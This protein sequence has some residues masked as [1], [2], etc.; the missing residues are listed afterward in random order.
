MRAS[1][2]G[3]G[4]TRENSL[5][6][7]ALRRRERSEWPAPELGSP[8]IDTQPSYAAVSQ[9]ASAQQ[10]SVAAVKPPAFDQTPDAHLVEFLA[11]AQ[12]ATSTIGTGPTTKSDCGG[13]S[14][15]SARR[16]PADVFPS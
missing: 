5:E 8:L 12:T 14:P 3:T 16:P 9:A 11:T 10:Q 4:L 6:V 7:T 13:I 15:N 1:S 2:H